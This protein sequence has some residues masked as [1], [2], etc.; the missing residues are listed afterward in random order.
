MKTSETF[1]QIKQFDKARPGIP[2]EH[3]MTLGVG[4]AVWLVTRNHSSLIVRTAGM[5]VGTA[6]VGRAASGRDGLARLFRFLPIGR[7]VKNSIS[8]Q[9]AA[10]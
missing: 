7:K 3:W 4:L 6:F 5:A 9:R 1:E 10:L 8:D 2:G